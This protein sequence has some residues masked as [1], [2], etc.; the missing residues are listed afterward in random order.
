MGRSSTMPHVNTSPLQSFI[1]R[2]ESQMIIASF[3]SKSDL[4]IYNLGQKLIRW[5]LKRF[6]TLV[7]IGTHT[8]MED[9]QENTIQKNKTR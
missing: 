5:K 8:W 4:S 2:R 9:E 7:K 3:M 6:G 1:L